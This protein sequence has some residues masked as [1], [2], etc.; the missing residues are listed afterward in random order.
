VKKPGVYLILASVLSICLIF[1]SMAQAQ[2]TASVSINF[3]GTINTHTP[4]SELKTAIVI[5]GTKTL[6]AAQQARVADFNMLVTGV[7]MTQSTLAGIKSI[8]PNIKIFVYIDTIAV[9]PILNT[10]QNPIWN[11]V[12]AHEDWFVHDNSGNRVI[13]T[14]WWGWYLMNVSSG[15]RDS[16][17][18]QANNILNSPYVDGIYGDDVLNEIRWT[19]EAG[20]FSDATTNVVLEQTDFPASYLNNWKSD[21]VVFLNYVESHI[22]SSK[23]FIIN[24]EERTTN[25]FLTQSDVDGKMGEGFAE[26]PTKANLI[27]HID[28]MIRD[29]AT[30]KIFI[31]ESNAASPYALTNRSVEFCYA[32]TLLGMNGD[33]CYFGYNYGQYYGYE[34]GANYMP[35]LVENLGNP[36]GA[37]YQSQSVYMRNFANGRVLLNPSDASHAVNLGGNYQLS[38]GTIVSSITLDPWSGEILLS[39]V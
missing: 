39:H 30:G 12:N 37:Y 5:Y 25:V 36:S 7:D 29:S 32:A 1:S 26:A 35:T 11:E 38:N 23:L 3:S 2:S 17:V 19:I 13:N 20:V 24:S 22:T 27:E 28:G 21:M 16:F 33:Q 9:S 18:Q 14:Y 34:Q 4:T 31:S 6:T 15:W 8:N 10:E